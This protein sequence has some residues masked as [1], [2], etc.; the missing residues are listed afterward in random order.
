[1][2]NTIPMCQSFK[3]LSREE[4]DVSYFE[5]LSEKK[6]RGEESTEDGCHPFLRFEITEFDATSDGEEDR[7]GNQNET[8]TVGE[9]QK[10][11]YGNVHEEL[12]FGCFFVCDEKTRDRDGLPFNRA[13]RKGDNGS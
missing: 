12:E 1:M 10:H 3:D 7:H 6:K 8:Q 13:W 9:I 2:S 11:H 5:W 4:R